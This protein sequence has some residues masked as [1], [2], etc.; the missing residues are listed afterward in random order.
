MKA[1]KTDKPLGIRRY[2]EHNAKGVPG[3]V[4]EAIAIH[5][6]AYIEK[7]CAA[8]PY[9]KIDRYDGMDAALPR[10]FLYTPPPGG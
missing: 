1:H 2:I 4:R 3:C 8:K 10:S 9:G 6:Q 7:E 5:M